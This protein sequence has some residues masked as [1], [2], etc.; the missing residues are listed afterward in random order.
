VPK[1]PMDA[2]GCIVR[3]SSADLVATNAVAFGRDILWFAF[4][5]SL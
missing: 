2:A 4:V 3:E 5:F 1:D